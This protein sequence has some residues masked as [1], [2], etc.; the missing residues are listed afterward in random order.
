[1]DRRHVV[2][3]GGGLGGLT[4]AALV[5]RAGV[6]V[7]VCE[8]APA[9]GG[10]AA[11]HVRDGFHLNLGAHALYLGGAAARE[12]AALGLP[13]AGGT[14]PGGW[15]LVGNELH[16]LPTGAVSLLSTGLLSFAA[17][18][19]AARLMARLGRIDTAPLAGVSVAEYLAREAP[20]PDLRQFLGGVIRVSTYCADFDTLSAGAAIAQVASAVAPGVRYLDGGW[21]SLVDGLAAAARAARATIVTDAHV[22]AIADIDAHG[23][24]AVVLRD[25]RRV[26]ADAV[27]VCA[28]PA[29]AASLV[30]KS[31]SLAACARAAHPARVA[32]L[33]V[34]LASLP[35]P[36]S[37]FA[38]GIDRPLY[39]SVH[40]G[41][42]RLAPGDGAVVH[43]MRYLDGSAADADAESDLMALCDRMQP[44]WR[45]RVVERR[46]LPRMTAAH[47]VPRAAAGAFAARAPVAV[48]DAPGVYVAGDWVGPDGMLADAVVGSAASAAR[49]AL[50]RLATA[51][52]A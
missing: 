41:A 8:R 1:M 7:T 42:A 24:R 44:G 27:I 13:L 6:A 3:V 33:D 26:D 31:A 17:K 32:C 12:L 28:S 40:S 43:L 51:Q 36:R 2:V 9:L 47:D 16:T 46:F 21:Q 20:E 50:A 10:R 29:L 22:D 14:P 48:A 49:L 5:A 38:L 11:T 19:R 4:A 39:F 52:A 45:D 25:G 37:R 30:P 18:R 34:A 15:G 35:R 23:R